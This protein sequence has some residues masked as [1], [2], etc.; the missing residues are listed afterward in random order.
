MIYHK[1]CR[2]LLD[3]AQGEFDPHTYAMR[4][5]MELKYSKPDLPD[6]K[7]R[8]KVPGEDSL[9]AL[10]IA[11]SL[12][13]KD[14]MDARQLGMES[15]C[16]LT[17]PSKTGIE[18]A[19]L[20]S[21]AVLFGTIQDESID[22]VEFLQD[23]LG[24]REAVLSLVQF[25]RLGDGDSKEGD[26]TSEES[27][28]NHP[29]EKEFNKILHNLALAVLANSLEVLQ[30]HSSKISP[31]GS[32][33]PS[34]ATN[35]FLEE[36]SEISNRELISTLLSVLNKAEANPH[37]ACLSAQCLRS[38]FNASKK[39]RRKAREM[40]AKEIVL[41]ALEVGKKSHVKLETET[42]NVMRVLEHPDEDDANDEE[43]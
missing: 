7:P 15:L 26:D 39:A 38:L 5:D 22:D 19:L 34:D 10:E 20:A 43:N 42:E 16:L 8:A 1:Y 17:D 11:A 35:V 3:A 25:G 40:N 21:R 6:R 41:T 33:K 28:G 14:R 37:E 32:S 9:L 23:E 36:S 4:E 29:E 24:V 31:N 27:M 12:L 2:N 18:T 30:N 13:K